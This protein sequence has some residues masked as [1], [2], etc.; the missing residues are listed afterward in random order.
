[1]KNASLSLASPEA[2]FSVSKKIALAVFGLGLSLILLVW[3]SGQTFLDA[4]TML[5]AALFSMIGGGV[6]FVVEQYRG[7][8]EGI[9]NNGQ[10][11]GSLTSRG[12]L[13][14]LSGIVFTVFYVCLYW[15]PEQLAGLVAL[16]SPMTQA[17]KG[18]NASQWDVYG[19]FY[20]LAVLV[21]GFKFI[22]KYRHS[23][24][25]I[26][27]TAS[28]MFFQLAFAFLLPAF[29]VS[30]QQPELFLTYFWPLSYYQGTPQAFDFYS[31]LTTKL[32]LAFFF[33]GLFMFFVATPILTYFFGKRWYCSWVCGCGGLAETAGDPF[34]HLSNKSLTAWKIERFSIHA[35][36]IL[37]VLMTAVLWLNVWTGRAVLASFSENFYKTY[38]FL[39]GAAFSGVVGVGFYPIFGSRVWCRFGCPMAAWLGIWQKKASKF[40]ITTNGGQ[41]ISCGN[42]ST[43]CEMGIDV[44]SYAQ[45]G[46]DIVRAS[47]VGC[48]VCSSVCPRGV[49]KLEN[50]ADDIFSRA[51]EERALHFSAD[52]KVKIG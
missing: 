15:F 30:M 26:W 42:C 36:L 39:I 13:G 46:Q 2:Q 20:T 38:S 1:M 48:G 16:F 50:V 19:A 34:R 7:L 52:G 43:H 18:Q 49:L 14:W 4:K 28:V 37:A 23:R 21:M 32:G 22:L 5:A 45:K 8:P 24:Y 29:L 25:Q 3:A 44:K 33:F 41:C 17:M 47:C 11:F 27:R 35:V 10:F 6:W 40:R 51:N 9:K 12:L 31:S